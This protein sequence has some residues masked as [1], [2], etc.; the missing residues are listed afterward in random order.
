MKT[1]ICALGM[2]ALCL[3]LLS[4]CTTVPQSPAPQVIKITC[5]RVQRCTMPATSLKTNGDLRRAFDQAENAWAICAAKVDLI[6]ACQE[7]NADE[8]IR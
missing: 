6:V 5:D 7:K 8:K 4:A 2:M 1:K 3:S